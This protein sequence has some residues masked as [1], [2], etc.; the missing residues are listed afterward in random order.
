MQ[1]PQDQF[2][3]KLFWLEVTANGTLPI[4]LAF[5]IALIALGA[6]IHRKRS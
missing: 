5:I 6:V 3:F 1:N 4:V 2:Q